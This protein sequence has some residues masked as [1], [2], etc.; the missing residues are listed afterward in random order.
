EA[1]PHDVLEAALQRITAQ[2]QAR[3]GRWRLAPR[4]SSG[5]A[6]GILAA[7]LLLFMLVWV[8]A[9]WAE[10][11]EAVRRAAPAQAMPRPPHLRPLLIVHVVCL[12]AAYLPFGLAW[13]ALQLDLLL[14]LFGWR[15]L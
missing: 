11:A 4:T 12:M 13:G 6:T 15:S 9:A 1:L 8:P 7:G 14:R 5:R 10:V 2:P 3:P